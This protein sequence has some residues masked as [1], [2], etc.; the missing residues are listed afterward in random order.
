MLLEIKTVPRSN[1]FLWDSE[2]FVSRHKNRMNYYFQANGIH[3][4]YQKKDAW[5]VS[6]YVNNTVY[7]SF[8]SFLLPSGAFYHCLY[9]FIYFVFFL[10]DVSIFPLMLH[11]SRTAH[12][13]KDGLKTIHAAYTD[14]VW[15]K[16]IY[17]ISVFLFL[18]AIKTY[19]IQAQ[20]KTFRCTGRTA[21][22]SFIQVF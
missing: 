1:G 4:A 7:G 18:K 11:E 14:K 21:P 10:E 13:G 19:I 3:K 16:W 2:N 22:V 8:P 20:C 5:G 6:A 9:L 17:W 12:S 15:G